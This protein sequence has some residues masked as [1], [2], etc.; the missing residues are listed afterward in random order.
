MHASQQISCA[1][2]RQCGVAGRTSKAGP[3]GRETERLTYLRFVPPN[4]ASHVAEAAVGDPSRLGEGGVTQATPCLW[5]TQPVG[6]GCALCRLP[7]MNS[8]SAHSYPAAQYST[9]S[10]AVQAGPTR[11][12]KLRATRYTLRGPGLTHHSLDAPHA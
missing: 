12:G 1:G 9:S 11:T 5:Q 10:S 6:E 7:R 8:S 3:E 2:V 4:E